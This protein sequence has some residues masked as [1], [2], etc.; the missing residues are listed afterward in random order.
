[1]TESITKGGA[2][3][4]KGSFYELEGDHVKR[5]LWVADFVRG[6]SV[7]D[8][9][10]GFGYGTNFLASGIAKN[11]V[12]VD[13]DSEAI[14][15]AKSTYQLP[16]LR[17]E[18]ADVCKIS[19]PPNSFDVVIS[20][21][22]IEHLAEPRSYL[23]RVKDLLKLGGQFI[24]STPNKLFTERTYKRGRPQNPFHIHEY[25]PTELRN[26]LLGYFSTPRVLYLSASFKQAALQEYNANC[27]IP[28]TIRNMIPT[29]VK[30]WWLKTRG[31]PPL[32]GH[33]TENW[34][35]FEIVEPN[36]LGEI[37]REI[38]TMLAI[39]TKMNGK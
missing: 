1:M 22:V 8:A 21:E 10:C 12:G 4:P 26:L 6:K 16:N 24:M 19:F 35:E 15:F 33:Q 38:V 11:I 25:Y 39:C 9:G 31:L 5:Y 7:L 29:S 18:V 14:K 34:R 28:K 32:T 13:S 30:D 37:N 27:R 17:L 23:E 3:R 20:F 36:S 2:I